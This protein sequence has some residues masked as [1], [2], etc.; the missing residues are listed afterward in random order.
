[1][2]LF[3][4]N[5]LGTCNNVKSTTWEGNTVLLLTVIDDQRSPFHIYFVV[6]NN[7]SLNDRSNT[8]LIFLGNK[9]ENKLFSWDQSL[10]VNCHMTHL[11]YTVDQSRAVYIH[12]WT[13]SIHQHTCHMHRDWTHTAHCVDTQYWSQITAPLLLWGLLS[14]CQ[15]LHLG[16][17]Q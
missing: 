16:C 1:M 17:N 7:V 15:S 10:S 3:P 2:K 13:W 9:S 12:S 14:P 11:Y 6:L 4:A 5:S 8:T